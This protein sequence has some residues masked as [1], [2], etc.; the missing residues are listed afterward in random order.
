MRAKVWAART[1]SPLFDCKKYAE[2]MEELFGK[3]WEKY[4]RGE[5]PDHID[6]S[7]KN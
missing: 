2:G 4:A 1:E 3:M 5:K 7:A 6:C